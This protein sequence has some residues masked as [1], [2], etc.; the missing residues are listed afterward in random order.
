MAVAWNEKDSLYI[1]AATGNFVAEPWHT[2]EGVR[3]NNASVPPGAAI[4]FGAVASSLGAASLEVRLY[5][6]TASIQIN[7]TDLTFTQ[8][9]V[10]DLQSVDVT[11]DLVAPAAEQRYRIQVKTTGGP[12]VLF[13]AE[14]RVLR[15]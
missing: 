6:E 10:E 8:G 7:N 4:H 3:F 5:D 13:G 12:C 15:A 1:Q 9:D 2:N 11:A 14:F